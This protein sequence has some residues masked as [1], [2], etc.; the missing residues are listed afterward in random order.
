MCTPS[1]RHDVSLMGNRRGFTLVELLVVIA[2][3]AILAGLLL[4][5]LA[6][7]KQR[8]SQ[9][10][11]ASNLK[12]VGHA[13]QMYADDNEDSLP[14]PTWTGA[15]ASYEDGSD[16]ELMYYLATYL[17]YPAP[18]D[19][20]RIVEV[21]VCPGY[22]RQAPAVTSME[23]RICFLL[24]SDVDPN[25]AE[26]V[27]PFGYPDPQI[28]PIRLTA[29]GNYGSPATLFATTDV[30]KIN[31]PNP[32]VGWW[33]DLPYKPVHGKARNELYFDWHVGNKP[34]QY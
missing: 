8:A 6:K 29:V 13:M 26:Q 15:R 32:T 17:G 3:I 12:Q 1:L 10:V 27:R 28:K 34:V 25:P 31:V 11:C 5:V 30:D 20:T 14:G 33:S 18:T 22:R 7:A 24:N 9:T 23:G 16:N 19:K 4:P 21:F 2:V